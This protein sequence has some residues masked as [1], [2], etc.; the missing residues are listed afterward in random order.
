MPESD[1][2]DGNIKI[3]IR[4]AKNVEKMHSIANDEK[5]PTDIRYGAVIVEEDSLHVI[6]RA[7]EQINNINY[8]NLK[9]YV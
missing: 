2:I 6:Q 5:L 1:S 4:M 3:I 9:T 7:I 8:G